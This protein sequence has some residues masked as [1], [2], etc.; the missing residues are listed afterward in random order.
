MPRQ[1]YYYQW[2]GRSSSVWLWALAET[3]IASRW[4]CIVFG[5]WLPNTGQMGF[6]SQ[7]VGRCQA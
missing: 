3:A 4:M 5:R 6:E 1:S 2:G 7:P